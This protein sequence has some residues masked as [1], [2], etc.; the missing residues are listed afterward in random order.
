MSPTSSDRCHTIQEVA[1]IVGISK[2][3][4]QRIFSNDLRMS[5]IC[6]RWVPH[7]LKEAEMERR[8]TDSQGFLQRYRRDR[9]FLNR[10]ITI[11]QT[12][13]HY[14]EPEGKRHPTIW[15][16]PCIPQT[17]QAK[18]LEIHGKSDVHGIYGSHTLPTHRTL[19]C[20]ILLIFLF[21]KDHLL[22]RKYED[23]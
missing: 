15:K 3:S 19:L 6:A 22:G 7:L 23:L 2:F 12:W 17:F 14:Y 9:N 16:A 21:F 1:E 8:V 20:K 18:F 4:V 13:V 11:D 5:L 10:I